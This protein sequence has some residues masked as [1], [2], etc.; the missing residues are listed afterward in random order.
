MAAIL[1]IARKHELLAIEDAACALGASYRGR[2]VGTLGT[3]GTF[4]FHPRKSITTGEGGAIVTNDAAL[5]KRCREWR[6]HGQSSAAGKREFVRPGLNYRMTEFQAA[7]G[8]AQLKKLPTILER[9]R[10][11]AQVYLRELGDSEPIRLPSDHPDHTW[12]TFMVVLPGESNRTETIEMLAAKG[13]T[14]GPGSVAGHLG[15]QAPS[16]RDLPVSA[17]L[18][19]QGLALPLFADLDSSSLPLIAKTLTA[20]VS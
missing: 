6:N 7:I 2:P 3:A 19:H 17:E 8:L 13:V 16:N 11:I 5:A 9:R 15:A 18:H 1:A 20:T 4:S 12:Q 14:A 10:Q